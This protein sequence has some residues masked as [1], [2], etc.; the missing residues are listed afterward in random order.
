VTF[1]ESNGSQGHMS[2]DIAGNENLPCEAI[3][4]LAIGEVKP[5]EKDDD[6]GRIWMTNGVIVGV[7]RW[8]VISLP[9]KQTHQSQV[10]QSL[11]KIFNHKICQPVW[12]MSK[13]KLLMKNLL[14][15]RKVMIKFKD[16]LWCLTLECTKAFKEIITWTTSL[17]ASGEG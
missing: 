15:K 14:N 11:K 13:N 10:I 6:E 1:D 5:Q 2:S 16:I 3:K 4:K 8:L 7:Q 9:P 12:K 17:V